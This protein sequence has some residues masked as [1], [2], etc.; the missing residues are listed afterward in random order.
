MK[1][2]TPLVYPAYPFTTTAAHHPD[3]PEENWGLHGVAV[4][5]N[6]QPQNPDPNNPDTLT[7]RQPYVTALSHWLR[8]FGG[9]LCQREPVIGRRWIA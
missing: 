1:N 3:W 4:A 9:C 5:N 8:H 7:A 6:R 2:G